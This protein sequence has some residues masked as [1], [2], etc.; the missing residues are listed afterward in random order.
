MKLLFLASLALVTISQAKFLLDPQEANQVLLSRE[1]RAKNDPFASDVLR[2]CQEK[3]CKWEEYLE[4]QENNDQYKRGSDLREELKA[5][6]R[7][8]KNWHKDLFDQ[9]YSDCWARVKAADLHKKP[10]EFGKACY[11]DHF[12]PQRE[13]Y[14]SGQQTQDY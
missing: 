2:E 14:Y 8:G 1:R 3:Q 11:K 13:Q 4:G 12:A 5:S 7:S 9:Y 6:K 10:F